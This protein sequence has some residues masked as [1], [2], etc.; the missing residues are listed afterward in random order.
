MYDPSMTLLLYSALPASWKNWFFFGVCFV[1]EMRLFLFAVGVALPAWQI[2]LVAFEDVNSRL[3]ALISDSSM[4]ISDHA[5]QT[6]IR[7]CVKVLRHLQMYITLLNLVNRNLIFT[8]KLLAIGICILSGY[9]AVAHFED[10]PVFGVMYYV[11]FFEVGMVYTTL[12]AKAFK[13]PDLFGEA[14]ALLRVRIGRLANRAERKIWQMEVMSIPSVG[15]QV[16][17]FHTLERTSTPVFLHYVLS[18]MVNMLVAYR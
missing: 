13:V 10:Y 14:K 5:T 15:I 4:R 11:L 9:A 18:N 1:E 17:E 3:E 7:L 12:Y 8:V 16:G 2:Q 6:D